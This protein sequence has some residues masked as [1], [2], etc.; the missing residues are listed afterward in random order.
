MSYRSKKAKLTAPQLLSMITSDMLYNNF[1]AQQEVMINKKLIAQRV[2]DQRLRRLADMC[3]RGFVHHVGNA[4]SARELEFIRIRMNE[5]LN[6]ENTD[7]LFAEWQG[8]DEATINYL[9]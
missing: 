4:Q 9:K 6:T 7:F 1:K 8:S 2:S 3:I 5:R